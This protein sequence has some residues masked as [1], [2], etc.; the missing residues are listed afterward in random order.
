MKLTKEE[1]QFI[2]NYL[3]NSDVI[4]ADI[5]ME[6][7][8]H[9]ASEIEAIMK[10][11][12]VATFYDVFIK[13]MVENKAS[14]LKENNNFINS[15]INKNT[16]LILKELIDY[17]TIILFVVLMFL[18]HFYLAELSVKS[19]NNVFGV[20]L[21][22]IVILITI[23]IIA[24]KVFKYSRFSGVERLGFMY[25]VLVQALNFI[26]III[27]PRIEEGISTI[28]ISTALT[29]SIVLIYV[30]A[31]VSFTIIKS[32]LTQYKSIV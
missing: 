32:Y 28:F 23:Y 15:V 22:L 18:S 31:K 19:I 5:R 20:P 25:F 3:E 13:Y 7:T 6:I 12:S 14:L 8:D 26:S 17:K 10:A 16:K 9:V 30:F 2:D 1:I 21:V 27:R 29:I 4:H 11:N 24:C